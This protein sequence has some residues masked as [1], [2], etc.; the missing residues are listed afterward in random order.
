M[1]ARSAGPAPVGPEPAARPPPQQPERRQLVD[2]LAR[3]G[4][5][6]RQVGLGERL[7][8]RGRAEVRTHHVRVRRVEDRRLDRRADE[9][10]G[11]GDQVGVERVVL[12]DQHPERVLR[13][14]AG[15]PDLLPERRPGPG[16]AGDEHGVEPADVDAELEGVGRGQP[17]QVAAAQRRLERPALLGEV[18]AAVGRDPVGQRGVDLGEQLGRRQGHLLRA[19]PRADEGQGAHVLGDEVGEQVGDLRRRGPAH[20][21]AVLTGMGGEGRLPQQQRHLPPWGVVAGQRDHVEAGEPRRGDLRLRDGRRGEHE[22]RVGAVHRA[23]PPQPAQHVGDV[24]PEHAAVVVALVDD[25][26]LQRPEQPRPPVVRGEQ[27][28]VEHVGVGEDVLAEVARPVPLLA[29]AV[30]VVRREPYVEAQRRQAGELVVGERLGRGEVEHRRSAL[31]AGPAGRADRRQRRQLVGQRLARRR[32][33][34]DDHVVAGVGRVGRHHLVPP[35]P[36]HALGGVRPAD[37][38]GHPL[39]P[40]LVHRLASGQ[41]LQVAQPLLPSGHAGQSPHER[42]DRRQDAGAG[43]LHLVKSGKG[44]GRRPRRRGV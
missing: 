1:S 43:G 40:V 20:R 9:L 32:A 10:V 27:R 25:D 22:R 5:E 42:V 12:G 38:V 35:R 2:D 6:E 11:V 13:A 8:L 17:D 34:R 15:P 28:P 30:A 36:R 3:R 16:E 37:V 33:R 4:A 21:R 44:R 14:T 7:L 29:R 41:H 24:R 26:V 31:A 39:R 23:H 19:A 18:A